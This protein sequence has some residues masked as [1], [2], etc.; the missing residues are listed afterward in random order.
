MGFEYPLDLGTQGQV[1]ETHDA[2]GD[3]GLAV[4]PAVVLG[5]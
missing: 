1:G 2:G 5:H 4:L 3:V